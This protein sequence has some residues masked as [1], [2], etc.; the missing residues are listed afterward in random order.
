VYLHAEIGGEGGFM[1]DSRWNRVGVVAGILYVVI[2]V[3]AGALTGAAARADGGAI[4]YQ[5]SSNDY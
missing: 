2:A 5:E 3:I 1:R 4:T